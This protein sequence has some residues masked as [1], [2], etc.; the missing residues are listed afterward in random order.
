MS[1]PEA[2]TFPV[3]EASHLRSEVTP[4]QDNTVLFLF[5]LMC[6]NFIFFIIIVVIT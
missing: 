2:E 4:F 6:T 1:I 3:H 5:I